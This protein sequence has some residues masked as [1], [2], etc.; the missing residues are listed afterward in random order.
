MATLTVPLERVAASGLKCHENALIG[1]LTAAV[2]FTIYLAEQHEACA[3][4]APWLL[5]KAGPAATPVRRGF[6]VHG[7]IAGFSGYISPA[8]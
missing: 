6:R 1:V 2:P 7:A 8:V 4:D 3:P 5:A